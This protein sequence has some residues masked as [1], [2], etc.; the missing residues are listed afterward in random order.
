MLCDAAVEFCVAV[1]YPGPIET[2]LGASAPLPDASSSS[3]VVVVAG[4]GLSLRSISMLCCASVACECVVLGVCWMCVFVWAL[5]CIV[6]SRSNVVV[7]AHV[8]V[9][10][11]WR[12][13]RMVRAPRR[14][15]RLRRVVCPG[16]GG[17]A[18]LVN[19]VALVVSV[20][21]SPGGLARVCAGIVYVR[22][23]CV[24][25]VEVVCLFI[26]VHHL[27]LALQSL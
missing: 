16:M 6:G 3:V 10:V 23:L 15:C 8:R 17:V 19:F 11:R 20:D 24:G 13:W 4:R 5:A 18:I 25:I 2:P 22:L 21:L 12:W 26:V 14:R 7:V 1:G 27:A 9:G